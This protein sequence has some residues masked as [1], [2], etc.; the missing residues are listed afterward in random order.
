MSLQINSSQARAALLNLILENA[1]IDGYETSFDVAA[2]FDLLPRDSA[3]ALTHILTALDR[4]DG[5]SQPMWSLDDL[6]NFVRRTPRTSPESTAMIEDLRRARARLDPG[7]DFETWIALIRRHLSGV[8]GLRGE[9][10]VSRYTEFKALSAIVHVALHNPN[11]ISDGYTLIRGDFPGIQRTIYTIGSDGAT[12]GVRGRSLFLQLLADC[13]VRRFLTEL[14]LPITN[15]VYIAGG[16]FLILAPRNTDAL[17]E[18]LTAQIGRQM[19]GVFRG[20]LSL[21]TA[22][23]EIDDP[24]LLANADPDR[25]FAHTLGLAAIAEGRYKAQ[26]MRT[27]AELDFDAVFDVE[28]AE[29]RLFC[30]VCQR[31]ALREADRK[32]VTAAQRKDERWTCDECHLFEELAVD[33]AKV[34]VPSVLFQAAGGGSGYAQRLFELTGW[35]AE[36]IEVGAQSPAGAIIWRMNDAAFDPDR[37]H[38]FRYLAVHTPKTTAADIAWWHEAYPGPY[39]AD[40]KP[41]A[42]QT[43]RDFE[44]LA[45]VY[46]SGE[47]SQF[48][49]LGVLR[50]DIDNLGKL[51]QPPDARD[52]EVRHLSPLTFTRLIAASDALSLFFEGYLPEL[53]A[54]SPAPNSLY[55]LY[56]GGDDL[57]IV[58]EWSI[59][60][61]LA[62]QIRSEFDAYCAGQLSISAGI[63]VTE[64]TFPFYRA[65]DHAKTA[66][67]DGAKNY[68][69]KDDKAPHKKDAIQFLGTIMPWRKGEDWETV[70]SQ[71]KHLV[72]LAEKLGSD[73]ITRTVQ[74]M[75]ARWEQDRYAQMARRAT[76]KTPSWN[77]IVYGPYMWLQAYQMKR[78]M[79][80]YEKHA[81]DIQA[82]QRDM[83]IPEKIR[84]AGISARWAELLRR[85]K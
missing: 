7:A 50:M 33:A 24:Y 47:T 20:D 79:K 84:L 19:L 57:F 43:I 38:G 52:P 34:R 26:P 67:D 15:A 2:Y 13:V 64:A 80:L 30:V 39:D 41:P 66:L 23:H 55:L 46:A 85:A 14:D 78:L 53:C 8:Q 81:A 45:N 21:I 31:E 5:I 35:S 62:T 72:D 4:T 36:I 77:Q 17:I 56:G 29:G 69:A 51:F 27:V 60:P 61:N 12:K 6:E 9:S 75:F 74:R 25:G 44:L 76:E 18:E 54:A 32:A 49:R 63:V 3:E 58:G 68:G 83:L 16:N 73:T 1:G 70:Q 28:G 22:T 11:G 10:G 48:P 65:A 37:E 59:M 42:V 71:R 40:E 82:V